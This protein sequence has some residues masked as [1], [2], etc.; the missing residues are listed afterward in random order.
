MRIIRN[1]GGAATSLTQGGS[2]HQGPF[3]YPDLDSLKAHVLAFVCA[4]NF[5]KHLKALRWKT[6]YQ[7]LV[8]TWQKNPAIFKTDPRHLIPG[9]YT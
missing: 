3:H 8:E 1:L 2:H 5:A 4:F 7:T 9:P 6:P